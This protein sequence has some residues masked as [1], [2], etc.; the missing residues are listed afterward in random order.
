MSKAERFAANAC[1]SPDERFMFMK[2]IGRL[3]LRNV[4]ALHRV[5]MFHRTDQETGQ[6]PR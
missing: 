1:V 2:A 3:A 5:V 4:S 6:K